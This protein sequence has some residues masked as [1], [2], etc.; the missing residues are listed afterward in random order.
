MKREGNLRNRKKILVTHSESR[1]LPSPNKRKTC[2]PSIQQSPTGHHQFNNLLEQKTS[3]SSSSSINISSIQPTNTRT[4]FNTVSNKKE[5]AK[6][7]KVEQEVAKKMRTTVKTNTDNLRSIDL[8]SEEPAHDHLEVLQAA[9]V[10]SRKKLFGK[11]APIRKNPGMFQK[12]KPGKVKPNATWK[13][14]NPNYKFIKRNSSDQVIALLASGHLPVKYAEYLQP[15]NSIMARHDN[16]WYAASI[17]KHV[18]TGIKIK[19]NDGSGIQLYLSPDL[20]TEL[21]QMNFNEMSDLKVQKKLEALEAITKAKKESLYL[22]YYRINRSRSIIFSIS[23][24]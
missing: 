21:R 20:G 12:R 19:W 16:K 4:A 3:S 7:L 2:S 8:V 10:V 1:A 24:F 23:N 18:D 6:R 9:S 15:G 13:S 11:N 14:T 5:N 22:L 17:L